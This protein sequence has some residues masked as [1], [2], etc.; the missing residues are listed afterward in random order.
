[1]TS[2]AARERFRLDFEALP[3]PDGAGAIHRVRFLLKHALRALG[4]RCT[5]AVAITP[6]GQ[7]IGQE[8]AHRQAP[9]PT[10]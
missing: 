9:A 5:R 8:L 3:N 2:K 1:M 10:H 4:L 7:E 6:D